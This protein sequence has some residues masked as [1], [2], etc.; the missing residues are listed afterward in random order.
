MNNKTQQIS[1]ERHKARG[2]ITGIK[3]SL[4]FQIVVSLSYGMQ[5]FT[6]QSVC[7][8]NLLYRKYH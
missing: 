7:C 3:I 1:K 5:I 4:Q 8:G 6:T 2:K